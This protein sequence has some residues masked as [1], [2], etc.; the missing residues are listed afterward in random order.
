MHM[1]LSLFGLAAGIGMPMQTSINAQLGRRVGSPF[2][3]ALINFCVGL[4]TMFL[5]TVAVERSLVMPVGDLITDSPWLFLGGFFAVFFIM[6][7]IL[8][9]PR[10]GSVQTVILPALGQIIMGT[11]IDTFGWFQ[12]AQRDMSLLRIIG[13][14]MVFGGVVI[15]IMSKSG[16]TAKAGA[17]DNSRTGNLWLWR[18]LGVAVGMS[19]AAQTAVNSHLGIMVESR[20]FAALIN[21]TVGTMILVI[22]NLIL[23][24]TKKPGIKE[25]RAPIWFFSGGLFGALFVIGNIITAHTVG[26]GMAVVILLTGLMTGGLLVDQFGLFHS[27]QRSIRYR[28]IGGIALM[29]AGAVL[30]YLA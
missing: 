30:F 3:A 4:G 18:F 6:G 9:M 15:V 5:I 12:S 17:A 27:A 21:L 19:M 28:E 25:G 13:V 11:L 8:M 20:L 26:T 2:L 29:V 24:K 7:N 1:F 16:G 22:L 14:A 10:I 23:L